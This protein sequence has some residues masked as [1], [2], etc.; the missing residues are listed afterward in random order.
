M[1]AMLKAR[2]WNR[3]SLATLNP[4]AT[5]AYAAAQGGRLVSGWGTS[6]TS[7]DSEISSSLRYARQRSRAS[8]RDMPFA[9]RAKRVVVNNVIGSGIGMQAQVK[10]MQGDLFTRVN[11]EIEQLWELWS[12][13]ENC[14]TGGKLHFSAMEQFLMGQVFE[15]GEIFIR[16]YYRPFGNSPVP[17]ALEVIE[18]ERVLDEYQ[19][20]P[21]DPR[22]RVRMGVEMDGFFRPVAYWIRTIHP[23]EMQYSSVDVDRIER[24]PA[25]QIIHLGVFERWPQTRCM[26]WMHATL[27]KLNDTDGYSEAEIIAARGGANFMGVRKLSSDRSEEEGVNGAKEMTL[28]PGIVEDIYQDEEFNL[29]STN[30]PNSNADTFLRYMLREIAAGSDVS[31]ESLS[32]DYSQSNYSSSRLALLDDRDLWKIFQLW[33][34]RSFRTQVH[35]EFLQQAILSRALTTIPIGQYAVDPRRF[36]KVRYKP[37]GWSWIDPAK[38][39]AAFRGGVKDGFT[40]LTDVIAKTADGRDIEDVLEERAQELVL[41]KKIEEKYKVK[42]D[43]DTDP[44]AEKKIQAQNPKPDL[45]QNPDQDLN[46][47]LDQSNPDDDNIARQSNGVDFD[48]LKQ[49]MDAFGVGVRAGALTP[50]IEDEITFRSEANLPTMSNA[51]KTAWRKDGNVRR[52]ITLQTGDASKSTQNQNVSKNTDEPKEE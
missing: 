3:K 35:R 1:N 52:P 18:P 2:M 10:T 47:D 5:R 37:R 30:R 11:T 27:R 12:E 49:K 14:H 7:A 28:E 24:V 40:T 45:E 8:M 29:L 23:G 13:A 31:Y 36:E 34:I 41:K 17:Y 22:M 44:G 4:P 38:E 51:V 15:A 26:P 25:D 19:P 16:K 33:F 20:G 6:V 32:R 50:Q 46:Q 48:N 9:K 43:F 21:G 39:E 42:L